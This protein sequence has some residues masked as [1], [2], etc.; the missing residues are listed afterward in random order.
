MN[1]IV[2]HTC[3]VVALMAFFVGGLQ[4]TTTQVFAATDASNQQARAEA[5]SGAR[6]ENVSGLALLYAEAMAAG[7]VEDWAPLDLGCLARQ[8]KQS[9][10][11]GKQLSESAAK[12]CW[13]ATMAAQRWSP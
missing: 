4:V 2:Q 6:T 11:S 8:Q 1:R 3:H 13:D 9:I 7:R 12:A 10:S 5:S